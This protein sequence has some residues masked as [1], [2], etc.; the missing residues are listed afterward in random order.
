MS[1]ET[2]K[3]NQYCGNDTGHSQTPRLGHMLNL[4]ICTLQTWVKRYK[5]RR[6]LAQLED[7]ILEDV[8]L[9]REQLK[10]EIMKPFWIK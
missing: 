5:N 7:H 2:L 4:T 6:Q 10:R 9:S 1:V 8:G 3:L